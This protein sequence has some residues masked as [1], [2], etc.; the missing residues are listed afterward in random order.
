MITN[1]LNQVKAALVND[2]IIA[3]PTETVYGLAA[4]IYSRSAI[5]KVY[6]LKM[7]PANNPLIVHISKP[8][9]LNEVAKNIPSKALELANVFWPGPLTLILEKN[10]QIPDRITAGKKTVAVRIPNHPIA[11]KLLNSLN[12]PLAAPSANPSGSISPTSAEHVSLYFKK[13]LNFIL[14]GGSC[15]HGLES[16][17]I[18]FENNNPILYRLGAITIEKIEEIIGPIKVKNQN[19]S[20]PSSPGMLSKHYSPK[21]QI[22]IIENICDAVKQNKTKKIGVLSLEKKSRLDSQIYQ[23]VLSPSGNIEEAA[24][25]FYAALHRLDHMNLDLIVTSFFPDKGIG[26]T[27]NDRLKRAVKK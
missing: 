2:D 3:L 24:K 11:L 17:I 6:K 25:N 4:N 12:F 27:I 13:E 15:L 22:Q 1:D 26:K 10:D 18:G 8:S 14:D 7:R 5:E 20:D 19:D 16:T 23:E 21:T 9:I